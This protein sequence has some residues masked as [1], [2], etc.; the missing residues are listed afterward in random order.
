MIETMSAVPAFVECCLL[1][2][3]R[4]RFRSPLD[5]GFQLTE[6]LEC[7]FQFVSPRPTIEQLKHAYDEPDWKIGSATEAQSAEAGNRLHALI[8]QFKAPG[9]D[10]LEVGCNNGFNLAGLNALGYSVAGTDLSPG[11]IAA[12]RD[13]VPEGRFYCAEFPPEELHNS[14]DVLLAVHVAEHVID[15]HAF[16]RRCARFLRPGGLFIIHTPNV[17]SIGI[18]LFARHY[19]VYCP[20]IHLNYFSGETLTRL[21][22]EQFRVE[23]FET[24]SAWTDPRNTVFNSIVSITHLFG[25][26]QRLKESKAFGVS[27]NQPEVSQRSKSRSVQL[28]TLIQR[29][30]HLAQAAMTPLFWMFNRADIGENILLVARKN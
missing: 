14:F 27:R 20:P 23:H 30:S 16:V 6:C 25:V 5:N 2:G 12:A 28:T 29:A 21:L 26:K 9:K 7:S 22:S 8:S 17:N 18:R 10:V 4:S 3:G 24:N 1:C 11:A 13:S 19:P 15:P